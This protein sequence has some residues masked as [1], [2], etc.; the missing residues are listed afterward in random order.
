MLIFLRSYNLPF[1]VEFGTASFTGRSGVDQSKSES[2]ISTT[3][4][5]EGPLSPFSG[6]AIAFLDSVEG[7]NSGSLRKVA[8]RR[9][10]TED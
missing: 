3:D 6:A 1:S 10:L 7:D 5:T 8:S 9:Q 2:T 4:S